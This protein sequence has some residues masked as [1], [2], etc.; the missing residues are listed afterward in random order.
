MRDS[1]EHGFRWLSFLAAVLV[2]LLALLDLIGWAYGVEML[3]RVA[4]GFASM[5]PNTAI[6]FIFASFSFLT[7]LWLGY[8]KVHESIRAASIFFAT[9][10]FAIGLLTLAEYVLVVDLGI[11]RFLFPD[12][13]QLENVPYPGR[14]PAAASLGFCF[15]GAGLILISAASA[16]LR[17]AGELLNIGAGFIALLSLI[18]F[19][20][21]VRSLYSSTIFSTVS[22][23]TSIAFLLLSIGVIL[24][25]G[26]T[27]INSVFWSESIGG[28]VARRLIPF[29]ILFPIVFGWIRS[30]GQRHGLYSTEFGTALFTI[31]NVVA[32]TLMLWFTA[33]SIEKVDRL[34]F[35]SS[36]RL[37]DTIRE[38]RDIE[39]A[40]DESAIVAVTDAKGKI[41]R[42][43]KAFCAISGYSEDELI[44]KDHRI[45]NS[46]YHSKEFIQNLWETI[47]AGKVWRGEIRNKR[48][49]GSFYWVDTTIVPFRELDGRPFQYVAIRH[50]I[51]LRRELADLALKQKSL[52]L[53]QSFE[54]I[55]I[56]DLETGVSEWNAGC[57]RLYGYKEDEVLGKKADV[58]LKS[59]YPVP[60]SEYMAELTGKGFWTSEVRKF[61]KTGQEIIVESRQQLIKVGERR[62][63]V[64]TNRDVT[65]SREAEKRLRESEERYRNLFEN[66]PFPMWVYDTEN[67]KFL[68]VNS[69]ATHFYGFTAED[70]GGMTIK[71]LRPSDEARSGPNSLFPAQPDRKRHSRI[72]KHRRKDG[73]VMDVEISSYRMA[74]DG[75]PGR[76]VLSIDVSD[77]IHTE[78]AIRS[79]NETLEEKVK[80]RTIE[81]DAVNKELESFAYSVSHD[82]RAPLRSIDGFSLAVLEDNAD[83]LNEEALGH[84][85]R[86][87]KASQRMSQLIEDL[88]N[89][90]RVSRGELVREKFDI[91]K[92]ARQIISSLRESD[93]KRSVDVEIQNGLIATGDGRLLRLAL[94]NLIGNAWKFTS[95][96]AQ[97][98]IQIGYV[99]NTHEFFVRD[100]GAGFDMAYA[101][102]LF[103]PFQ[104]LHTIDEFE[105]TGIGLATVQR[106]IHRH[107]G[108]VRAEGKTGEGAVFFFTVGR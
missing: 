32:L 69:A 2:L 31:A 102:E 57:E 9:I 79:L 64:T 74:F 101:D 63:V 52:L 66:N 18:D 30:E 15:V 84:L 107:G 14:I 25:V 45:I 22:I 20:Y 72:S 55:F 42:V 98:S 76:L 17:T 99:E 41:T 11:D 24:A 27:G 88:L 65:A 1:R 51:T 96:T 97:G 5:K 21:D 6:G 16:K 67:L 92:T 35:A 43:N 93:P 77:R 34:R 38:L 29:A 81:L 54:P 56:W 53:R 39:F 33:R 36:K 106:I 12:A 8:F 50:D 7:F 61:T 83:K 26:R 100:N 89:L 91:T 108:S 37:D 104:R 68:A 4:P 10:T 19:L 75:R 70:F 58:V 3:I 13:I 105:G 49:D 103:G 28:V 62:I 59:I 40:L 60:I 47:G 85:F 23:Q 90:S 86:V 48:K 82:L 73:S 80:E 71:D 44:G 95:K 78:E 94:E 46:S 87:R